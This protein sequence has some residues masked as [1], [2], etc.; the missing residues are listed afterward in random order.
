MAA[1]QSMI[2]DAIFAA[3]ALLIAVEAIVL[4][5]AQHILTPALRLSLRRW[6]AGTL[7]LAGACAV[8]AAV[9][10]LPTPIVAVA[11]SLL[12]TGGL[13]E[14]HR[15]LRLFR[16][17]LLRRRDFLPLAVATVGVLDFLFV[18]ASPA[19]LTA[20]TA[21][22]WVWAMS[23]CM[24]M[25]V[26]DGKGEAARG[27]YTMAGIFAL[28][29]VL[30]LVPASRPIFFDTMPGTRGDW[31][32]LAAA[33]FLGLLPIVGAT[34]FL[35][36]CVDRLKSSLELAALTDHLTDLS[37]RRLLGTFGK[38]MFDRA[39]ARGTRFSVAIIDIDHFKSINDSFGHAVGDQ[40]LV[41][42]S[43]RL[44]ESIRK[45]DFIARSG[46]EEFVVI[47]DDPRLEDVQTT[48]ERLRVAVEC[49]RFPGR[50]GIS[51][52]ISAGVATYHPADTGFD[53]VLQRADNAMYLAKS[54]G[55]NRVELADEPMWEEGEE[56]EDREAGAASAGRRG[57]R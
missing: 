9:S 49:S 44:K 22:V 25:I 1:Q 56:G 50:R 51:V 48:V 24:R 11:S 26:V 2:G 34:V 42:V 21:F 37:N 7:T 31:R 39:R 28:A 3:L 6:Q 33:I 5:L 29:M 19:L 57:S 13:I 17:R 4:S 55:R 35:L 43:Q 30:T 8:C 38:D 32:M 18:C 27:R 45:S 40:V 12:V 46:G 52:T 10:V 47:L 41:H 54:R 20:V 14:Y 23:D 16:G 53:D 15:S 36:M